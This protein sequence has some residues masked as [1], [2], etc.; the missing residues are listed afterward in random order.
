MFL[1]L[2]VHFTF[3]VE[4]DTLE[5]SWV[6]ATLVSMCLHIF[7]CLH[8]KYLTSFLAPLLGNGS[9]SRIKPSS[10]EFHFSFYHLFTTFFFLPLYHM[11]SNPIYKYS[12]PKGD[13]LEPPPSSHPIL[14]DGYKLCPAFL[15]MVWDKPFSR[16]KDK[17]LYTHLREFEH[18]CSCL[19]IASMT[20]E[21][22]KWKLFP[23]SLLG[24]AK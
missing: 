21:T 22:I 2:L 17:N 9:C 15:A 13:K 16:L 20:Q 10:S 12:A 7:S 1:I 23:L 14:T 6:K 4:I 8:L 5:Y 24:K 3:P 11:Y 18:L 19:A